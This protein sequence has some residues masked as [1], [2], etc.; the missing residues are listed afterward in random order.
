MKKKN[1]RESIGYC[2]KTYKGKLKWMHSFIKGMKIFLNK[3]NLL[4]IENPEGKK[5]KSG[6]CG[7]SVQSILMGFCHGVFSFDLP[8]RSIK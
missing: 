6:H 8:I 5:R 1:C 4:D 3:V 7:I 2:K